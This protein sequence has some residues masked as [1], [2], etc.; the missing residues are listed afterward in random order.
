MSGLGDRLRNV[1]TCAMC[2]DKLILHFEGWSDG[3]DVL[4]EDGDPSDYALFSEVCAN[5][6]CE[7]YAFT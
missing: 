6:R 5:P 4:P 2:G 1:G 7:A 3:A